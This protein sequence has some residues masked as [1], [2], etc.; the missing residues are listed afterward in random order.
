MRAL[1][2]L[3]LCAPALAL[4]GDPAPAPAPPAEPA[5]AEAPEP[6]WMQ[7]AAS[8]TIKVAQRDAAADALVQKTK[9]LGGYFSSL[10]DQQVVLRVPTADV[11]ALLTTA[12]GLGVVVGRSFQRTDLSA[13][14]GE[15]EA[16]LGAREKVLR[17]YLEV[18][19]DA[20]ANA[21]VTVEQQ[22]TSLIGEIEGLKG[23]L[24][25]MTDRA[26]YG[27]VTIAFQFRERAA[28]AR[29]G[30]SSFAWLNTM[31][32]ADVRDGF[33][34]PRGSGRTRGVTAHAPEGFAVYEKRR[35]F[36]ATSP[37]GV[38]YSVRT[39][40]NEPEATLEFWK[41]ALH[42]RMEEAGYTVLSEGEVTASGHAGLLLHTVAPNGRQDDAYLIALF[43]DG[44]SL[45]IVESVGE[46]SR[47]DARKDAIRKAIEATQL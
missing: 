25:L 42:K 35:P 26:Q 36:R 11:D 41:E 32:L 17:M 43:L 20:N 31:N 12:E 27:T 1:L 5:P 28:P 40:P 10:S 2:I 30:D 9:D 33:R 37:D 44:G 13:Q 39:L 24:R 22:I 23:Q 7:V 18:L 47:L 19:R 6:A 45:V 4:A 34:W 46:V 14:V 16:R 15:V 3:A 8:L 29:R 21:V 38:L